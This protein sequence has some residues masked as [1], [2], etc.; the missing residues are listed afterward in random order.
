M[1]VRLS[2]TGG[3]TLPNESQ[4]HCVC[5]VRKSERP[6]RLGTRRGHRPRQRGD[7]TGSACLDC[8]HDTRCY[9]GGQREVPA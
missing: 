9:R 1:T 2:S 8:G 7:W 5:E 4:D 3:S 6:C